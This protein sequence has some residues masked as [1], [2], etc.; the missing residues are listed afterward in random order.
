[1]VMKAVIIKAILF[2]SADNQV[3]GEHKDYI[4]AVASH[5]ETGDCVASV[6]DDHTCCIWSVDSDA[7]ADVVS[8]PLTSPGMAVCF[9]PQEPS[10]VESI[11]LSAHSIMSSL[12]IRHI[13]LPIEM[14][15]NLN[16]TTCGG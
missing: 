12:L 9:H 8:F 14:F 1:M 2:K 13:P 7:A 16:R 4:N 3:V 6:S 15:G 11:S 10:K 5:P